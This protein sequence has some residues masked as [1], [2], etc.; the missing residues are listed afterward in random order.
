MF[1]SPDH[2]SNSLQ[3]HVQ[4]FSHFPFFSELR[5]SHW[6][7]TVFETLVLLT[8]FLVSVVGNVS[9]L[10]KVPRVR[11]LADHAIFTFNLFLADL[12]F[13]STIPF[14]IAVRWTKAWMLGSPT[15][16]VVMYFISLSG[17]VS[18]TMLAAISVDRLLAI[19]KMEATPSLNLR[20]SSGVSLLIWLFSAVTLLPLSVFSRVVPVISHEQEEILICTLMWPHLMGEIAWNAIFIALGFLLP[21]TSIVISY[22]KILQIRQHSK[23]SLQTASPQSHPQPCTVSSSPYSRPQPCAVSKQD[24]KLFRTLLVLVVS[25]FIMWTPI[26]VV[27]F[28]IL[29][30]NFHAN[31]PITSSVFFWVVTF[32]MANSAI[33]PILY[34]VCHL[35]NS[36]HKICCAKG[37]NRD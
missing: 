3:L 21:G 28:L 2:K 36:W 1:F 17:T 15:C 31:L 8:I 32:T 35:R 7:V 13:V 5:P 34:S 23:W 18:I 37:T 11:R 16:Q 4:N 29:I 27:T 25:F 20:R 33:N 9:A 24:Y 14:I 12:L 22:S 10:V 19:L 6:L 30:R 26:F